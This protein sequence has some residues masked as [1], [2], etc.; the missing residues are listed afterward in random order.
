MNFIENQNKRKFPL[1]RSGQARKD[2]MRLHNKTSNPTKKA[3]KMTYI[4]NQNPT[5]KMVNTT[6]ITTEK[7]KTKQYKLHQTKQQKSQQTTTQ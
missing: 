2:S 3:A 7:A 6:T 5:T 1:D 4:I